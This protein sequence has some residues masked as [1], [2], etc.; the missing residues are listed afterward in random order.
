MFRYLINTH[1]FIWWLDGGENLS[2]EAFRIINGDDNGIYGKR[3]D[4]LT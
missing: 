2:S 3:N 4:Y 1:I